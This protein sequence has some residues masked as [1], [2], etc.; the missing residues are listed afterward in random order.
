MRIGYCTRTNPHDKRSWSGTHYF[1]MKSLKEHYEE[2]IPL[3]P[4]KNKFCSLG[5]ALNRASKTLLKKQL[6]YRHSP[7]IGR[8]FAKVLKRK[9][10]KEKCDVLFVPSG[11]V[12]IAR[13]KTEIPIISLFDA[14]IKGLIDYYGGYSNLLSISKKWAIE[15]DMAAMEKSSEIIYSSAWAAESAIKEYSCKQEKAHIIP[16]GANLDNVP[17]GGEILL[18]REKGGKTCKLFFIGVD[19]IRKGGKIAFDT[20]VELNRRGIDTELTVCGCVPPDG[21][22]HGKLKVIK[23]LDKNNALHAKKLNSLYLDSSFLILPTRSECSAI[24]YCESAAYCLPVIST[25]TGG[26]PSYV[27]N[28]ANGFLLSLEADY[29]MYA[30]V[31]ESSWRDKNRYYKLCE[32]SREKY[33][34]ELNWNTWGIR[35]SKLI[36]GAA[37]VK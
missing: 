15:A 20:M 37:G 33:E 6:L 29:R 10:E 36:N 5:K 22:R 18:Y 13:L 23:F 28:G 21:V 35:V 32:K 4:L 19:W 16:F 26:V 9:A 11:G 30:D 1:I 8:E 25:Q 7:I 2:V 27:E 3:G 17:P 34:K 31:I 12:L 24:V 14:T